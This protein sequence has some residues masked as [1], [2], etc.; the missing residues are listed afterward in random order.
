MQR[1]AIRK[2][3]RKAWRNRELAEKFVGNLGADDRITVDKRVNLDVKPPVVE[4][5]YICYRPPAE[6][7]PF[8]MSGD[9]AAIK[10]AIQSGLL[11]LT[12]EA[13]YRKSPTNA[14]C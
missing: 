8:F 6:R 11:E 2:K 13:T 14:T 5:T 4:E 9:C 12:G 10:V 3:R 7:T 1:W